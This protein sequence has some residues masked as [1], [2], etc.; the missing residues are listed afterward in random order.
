MPVRAEGLGAMTVRAV[1]AMAAAAMAEA[2][3]RV[4][5]RV[6]AAARSP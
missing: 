4:V 1:A 3:E 2:G 6:V 5:S